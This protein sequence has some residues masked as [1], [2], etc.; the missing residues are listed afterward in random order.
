[1]FRA[2]IPLA[3]FAALTPQNTSAQPAAAEI[4]G[5]VRDPHGAA[6]AGSVVSVVETRTGLQFR[7]ASSSTGAYTFT[8]LRPGVYR[9]EVAVEGFKR[10][11][12]QDI[13]LATGERVRIDIALEVGEVSESVRVT[14]D[15][16]LLRTDTSTLG[17]VIHNRTI[18]D[19]PLNGR[20]FVSLAALAPGVALPPGSVFPRINGG[21]PRVNEY[22]FDGISVLQPE[23]GQVAFSPVID[24]IQEFKVVTNAPEAEFG[25]FDG[26]VITLTTKSGTNDYHGTLFEFFRHEAFN[27]RNLFS[28]PTASDPNEVRFR[29]NQFGGVFGGPIVREKTFFFGDYQG[30]R[31]SIGRVRISTVPTVL[32]RQGSFSEPVSG[33][34]VTIHDPLTTRFGPSGAIMRDPF[35]GNSIPTTRMD[36]VAR[37]LLERYPLPTSGDTASNYRRTG[38]E[39]TDQQQFDVRIDHRITNRDLA[40][41]RYSYASDETTPVTPLPDGSGN[42]PSGAAGPIRTR[43]QALAANQVHTFTAHAVNEL[44]LGYT[45][46]AVVRVAASLAAPPAQSL[47]LPGL[48]TNSAFS[49]LLPAILIDGYQQLGSPPNTATRFR[50]DVTQLADALS[51]QK[52]SHAMKAGIDFRWERLDIVQ[53]PA[54]SGLFHFNALFTDSPGVSGTGSPL[55]SFLLGQVNTF[56]VDVQQKPLRPRARTHE[57]FVQ[58]DWRAARRLTVNAGL[59]YTLNF[60]S[61]EVDDQGA[62][63]N[64]ATQQLDY[65][66]RN[67]FPRSARKLHKGNFGPRLGFAF[68]PAGR[69]VVRSAYALV[70]FQMA[71]ISSSF[72]NPQFPFVQSVGQ[73]TLDNI[74]PA[75]K[76]SDGPSVAPIAPTPDAGLGQGVYSVDRD[77]GSGYAQHWNFAVQR[78][79]AKDLVW[80]IAYTGSKITHVGMPDVNLNQLTVDQLRAGAWLLESVPN[81][82]FGQIP[83]S[84]SLGG[85]TISRAHL[86]KPFPRF[87]AVAF[88]R[89]NAGDTNFHGLQIKL[90][91]RFSQGLSLTLSYTRSKLIDEASAVFNASVQA[92]AVES[93]P[94]ADAFNRK[95]E[96]DVSNGDIPNI[97]AVSWSYEIPFG[98]R[99]PA[100]SGILGWIGAGWQLAGLVSLQS[101]LPLAISQATNYN[102]FAGFGMQRPNRLRD[103]AL[104]AGQRS[105]AKWFDTSAF[106]TAP[107]FTIGNSS[108]NPVR[109][110]GHRNID[111][112][113]SKR[114]PVTEHTAVELRVE[115]F[116]LTNTPPLGAP[117][118]VFGTPGFGVIT[119]AGDPRV[120]QFAVKLHF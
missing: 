36:S 41:V 55:A 18:V 56:S 92:G 42:P 104:P 76:L 120:A 96:R 15:A 12:Q 74:R 27:A 111:I 22:L 13:R 53:P 105:T 79:L 63:F 103:P 85:P 69:T 100:R 57:F 83:Q 17:Q 3:I 47:G 16:P 10:F 61:T 35:P 81:P 24:A 14:A 113:L 117:N 75:F 25:R 99:R 87:T 101:G 88:Y 115:V 39:L 30:T 110:P 23:P 40:Y 97:F 116:N 60:P 73:R 31:Q 108:R 59:R 112:A 84:S 50:T 43:A 68:Q 45:R 52:G 6:V 19:L 2:V 98:R 65:L 29:R 54:P 11:I 80:E 5:S 72:I 26:G 48:P 71:G 4:T 44:R 114:T 89:N 32:Q 8:N 9:L 62:V 58:D 78:E 7:T 119:S 93:S 82:F 51:F 49:N 94:V 91:K 109:G 34:A 37:K 106:Q 86:L 67:G 77:L 70:W 28:A 38:K 64:L 107:V 90:E 20:T 95:L 21:R 46:R 1:M 102:A 33:R 118:M 66:G